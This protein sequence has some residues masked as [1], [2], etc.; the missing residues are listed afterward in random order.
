MTKLIIFDLDGTVADSPE[1]MCYTCNQCLRAY[2]LTEQ[3]VEKFKYFAGDGAKTM[4]ER[5]LA[6]A[7][8]PEL[9][10]IEPVYA[11]YKELFADGCTYHVKSFPGLPEVLNQVKERGILIAVCTN[12]AHENAIRVVETIYGEGFFDMIAGHCDAYPKKPD[13]ASALLIARKLDVPISNI[14]YVGDTNTDMY[15]G[16]NAG[17]YTVGVTWGFRDREELESTG[18]DVIIDR[19]EQLLDV[20]NEI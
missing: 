14:V 11:M 5:A 1:S 17:M 7:G 10:L 19:P 16:K 3:P 9:E 12:K 13:P 2:G 4:V 18:A 8:D 15:T 20:I 6:E